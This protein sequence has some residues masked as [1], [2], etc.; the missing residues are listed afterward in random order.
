MSKRGFTTIVRS[1]TNRT[2]EQGDDN[3]GDY[4]SHIA[5]YPL[6][7][8]EQEQEIARTITERRQMFQNSVLC[9]FFGAHTA[10]QIIQ[11]SLDTP[12]IN[13]PSVFQINR[14]NEDVAQQR[15]KIEELLQKPTLALFKESPLRTWVLEQVIAKGEER[16]VS[17][18]MQRKQTTIIEG[19]HET[20]AT[21]QKQMKDM[22]KQRKSYRQ[23]VNT[24]ANHNL[25]LVVSVAKKYMGRGLS[26]ADCI[27]EG[28]DG[29]LYAADG[30]NPHLQNRF[31]TY[32]VWWIHN[33][34][35]RSLEF[36]SRIIHIPPQVQKKAWAGHHGVIAP[37][38]MTNILSKNTGSEETSFNE[39]TPLIST[40]AMVEDTDYM[41]MAELHDLFDAALLNVDLRTRN[42]IRAKFGLDDSSPKTLE[43]IAQEFDITKERVRQILMRGI[44]KLKKTRYRE[45]L[46][47]FLE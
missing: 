3:M 4:L 30:F 32:A 11:Q 38:C 39:E 8:R 36:T 14:L 35:K 34:I 41:H 45:Q 21:L 7:S 5:K 27:Q 26:F 25:R 9:S 40:M 42:I 10:C 15:K 31:S 29:L 23:A 16:L 28:N 24:L 17:S 1:S 37:R 20:R 13:R 6:L 18:A 46:L 22:K 43:T 12:R 19:T 2:P 47:Q 44:E 33:R